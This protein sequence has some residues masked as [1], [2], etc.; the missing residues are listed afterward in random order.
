MI[1]FFCTHLGITH[2]W[3]K[4]LDPSLRP[5][6]NYFGEYREVLPY[7]RNAFDSALD[8]FRD[9]V[10]P[11]S[12]ADEL[13]AM[14]RQLCDPDPG[15]RGHPTDRMTN[16]FSVERYISRFDALARRAELGLI[17]T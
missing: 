6:G 17:R 5:P 10:R 12:I 14:V 13:C 16:Q 2:L 3:L 8:E 1:V 7:I 9:H 15:Y 4:H 11:S